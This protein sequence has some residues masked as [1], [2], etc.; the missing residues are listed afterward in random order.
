MI[1]LSE[2]DLGALPPAVKDFYGVVLGLG[3]DVPLRR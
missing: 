2:G 3:G 1:K